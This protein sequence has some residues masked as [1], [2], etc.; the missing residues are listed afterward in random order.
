MFTDSSTEFSVEQVICINWTN[1][2]LF[3][4]ANL[5]YLKVQL[6]TKKYLGAKLLDLLLADICKATNL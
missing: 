1:E 5:K 2:D 3:L 4:R 6:G